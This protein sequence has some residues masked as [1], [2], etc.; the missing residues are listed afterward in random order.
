MK[1]VVVYASHY[2]TTRRYAVWVATQ[3]G[4]ECIEAISKDVPDPAPYDCVIM[5]GSVYAGGWL[6]RAWAERNAL[7]LEG[8]RVYAFTVSTLSASKAEEHAAVVK[9]NLP[10][11]LQD[12]IQAWHF[13]G[14]IDPKKLRFFH[15]IMFR[16]VMSVSKD[17]DA[18]EKKIK[19][20][21]LV[22]RED[23]QPLVATVKAECR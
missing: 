6:M 16:M 4:F 19:G 18:H 2:G 7:A 15:R 22:S 12:K 11:N 1:G 5:G 21:D 9:R 23:I 20:V 10:K 17:P 3:L 13:G 8:K 14:A